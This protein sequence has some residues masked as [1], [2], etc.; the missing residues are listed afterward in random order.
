MSNEH[1]VRGEK[2]QR[3][4]MTRRTGKQALHTRVRTKDKRAT[5]D[6]LNQKESQMTAFPAIYIFEAR[7]R[8]EPEAE[9]WYWTEHGTVSNVR[10]M[11]QRIRCHDQDYID[12]LLEQFN[13]MFD[14][15]YEFTAVGVP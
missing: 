5:V 3:Y 7:P 10:G 1:S 6:A 15:A 13:D 12:D 11:A 4:T 14:R 8:G 2:P 9:P